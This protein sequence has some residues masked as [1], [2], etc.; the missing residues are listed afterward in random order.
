MAT[1]GN[2]RKRARSRL[3][4][5]LAA[6]F[7]MPIALTPPVASADREVIPEREITKAGVLDVVYVDDFSRHR[8]EKHH[9]LL[10]E[11]R[12]YTRLDFQFD[13]GLTAGT[14]IEVHGIERDGVLEP[15]DHSVIASPLAA[16]GRNVNLGEQRTVVLLV[17]S[18]E[19]PVEPVTELEIWNRVFSANNPYSV[20]N[21]F[22]E[23]S[24]EKTWLA[25]HVFGW[26]TLAL[27]EDTL[28]N[29][30]YATRDAAVAAADPDVYYPD[31]TRLM[32]LFPAAGCGWG[33][34]GNSALVWI[35]TDDG[36][37]QMSWSLYNSVEQFGGTPSY[38]GSA[39]HELGHNFGCGHANDWECGTA[40]IGGHCESI[41]YGNHFD[42]M[43]MA[44]AKGHFDAIHKETAGWFDPSHVLETSAPGRYLIE[45]IETHTPGLKLLRIPTVTYKYHVEYRRPI[46]FDAHLLDFYATDHDGAVVSM[47]LNHNNGDSQLLDMTPH[48][49]TAGIPQFWDSLFSVLN[50]TRR[51]RDVIFDITFATLSATEEHLIVCIPEAGCSPTV[52]AFP[53]TVLAEGPDTLIWGSPE[54]VRFVRGDLAAVR[55][56]G[57]FDSGD[58]IQQA[59]LDISADTPEA[60]EG[61]WYLVRPLCCGLWQT[62]VGAEPGREAALP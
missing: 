51:Y 6:V 40:I 28:C 27:D 3:V 24:Y 50:E 11:A 10:D 61:T 41:N 36:D 9:V 62:S 12:G 55:S 39:Y 31:Y 18:F 48:D 46:G 26:Y 35:P 60:G 37:V 47:D 14:E 23:V 7:L 44:G 17:N 34:V 43:G 49:A 38:G 2:N 22:T 42:A 52:S 45:P 30:W 8:S 16:A 58:L 20:T 32:I 59:E 19:N 13:P 53:L 1:F 54:D 57:Y 15:F 29:D 33:G 21:Y 4:G 25:G 56:Y 5:C